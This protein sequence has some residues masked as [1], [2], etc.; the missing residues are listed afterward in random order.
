MDTAQPGQSKEMSEEERAQ[1]HQEQRRSYLQDIGEAVSNL[2]QPF[3][4]KV[5][6]DVIDESQQKPTT[7]SQEGDT[8]TSTAPPS[9]PSGASVNTVSRGSKASRLIVAPIKITTVWAKW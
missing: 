7:T 3:G 1:L 9:V 2:L 4:V 8:T 5:D 6:V